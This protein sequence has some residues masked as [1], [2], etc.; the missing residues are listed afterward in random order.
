MAVLMTTVL[1]VIQILIALSLTVVILMQRSEGGALGMG[2]S[3]GG[4]GGMMSSRSAADILTRTTMVLG[5]LF[6]VNCIALAIFT[7]VDSSGQSVYDR[8][9]N[10]IPVIESQEDVPPAAQIPTDG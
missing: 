5:F 2:G 10:D 6:I 9:A 8:Q 4:G 7:S 1:L 3:G